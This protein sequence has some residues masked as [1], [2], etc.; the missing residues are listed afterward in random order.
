L[1]KDKVKLKHLTLV[2]QSNRYNVI[3]VLYFVLWVR[4]RISKLAKHC[5]FSDGSSAFLDVFHLFFHF[6][7]CLYFVFQTPTQS[8]QPPWK[9]LMFLSSY[10][11]TGFLSFWPISARVF[12]RLFYK[13]R[14]KRGNFASLLDSI[15][16]IIFSFLIIYFLVY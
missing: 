3:A 5:L 11:N 4:L 10:R 14:Y 1:W 16:I 12:K 7:Y 9:F 6:K 13:T 15:V 8:T 2:K